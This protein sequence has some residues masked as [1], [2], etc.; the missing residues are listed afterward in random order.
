MSSYKIVRYSDRDGWLASRSMGI[1]SSE[2]GTILGLNP[3]ETPYQLW[4]RKKGLDGP[5]P[6][7]FAMKAGHYLED[8]VSKFFEDATGHTIIK[9]SAGDW[10]AINKAKPYLRVSPDRTYWLKNSKH[11]VA[12]KGICECKTTQLY[13]DG[14]SVPR[15]WFCQLQYQMYVLE[16]NHGALAWL[17]QGREFG[18]REY[19]LDLGFCKWMISRIEDF[20]ERYINGDEVP[21]DTTVQ[22]V[23]LRYPRH[24]EGK[25]LTATDELLDAVEKLREVKAE[26]AALDNEKKAAEAVIKTAM[27]D[28]E[29]VVTEGGKALVT[30]RAGKD[31]NVFDEKRFA[32]EHADLYA[33]YKTTRPASRTFL[34]K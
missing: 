31:R 6:E 21:A 13:V 28:A 18:Y 22:D 20:M 11:T 15:H 7:N 14:D 23:Q 10:L 24:A 26:M 30:W 8:A 27:A 16:V 29:A 19:N 25:E 34:L 32:A 5:K 3:F 1:G 2:V 9:A 33:D 17:T 12:N 4:R